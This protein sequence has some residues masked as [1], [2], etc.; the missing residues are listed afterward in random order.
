MENK[1]HFKAL[2]TYKDEL[3]KSSL[4]ISNKNLANGF[5]LAK[6]KNVSVRKLQIFKLFSLLKPSP[7]RIR[8]FIILTLNY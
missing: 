1:P 3:D 5:I 2:Q 6:L 7:H 8:L 4:W